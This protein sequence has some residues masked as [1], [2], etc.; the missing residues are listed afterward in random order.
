[1]I[2]EMG[3][4]AVRRRGRMSR[5]VVEKLELWFRFKFGMHCSFFLPVSVEGSAAIRYVYFLMSV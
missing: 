5:E 2:D 1:M 4:P 3:P